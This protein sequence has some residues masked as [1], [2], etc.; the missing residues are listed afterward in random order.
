[1]TRNY[2]KSESGVVRAI[3]EFERGANPCERWNHDYRL[4]VTM[5]YLL[6]HDEGEATARLVSGMRAMERM[7]E[8]PTEKRC[9][10]NETTT[11]FWMAIARLFLSSSDPETD[12]LSVLNR[13]LGCYSDR[14]SLIHEHYRPRTLQ[15]WE[16][17]VSWV[18]PDLEPLAVPLR[19]SNNHGS[20]RGF[21]DGVHGCKPNQS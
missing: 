18:E 19:A 21:S 7:H 2:F 3:D 20:A 9:S 17:R 13:F 14:E 10:Y 8:Q 6:T 4:V 5:W 15:S 1:M 11:V 12:R 16:A